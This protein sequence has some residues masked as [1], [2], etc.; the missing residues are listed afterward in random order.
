MEKRAASELMAAAQ[1]FDEELERFGKLAEAVNRGPLNSQKT[2]E[3]AA[4]VFDDIGHAEKRLS[5]VAQALVTALNAARQQQESHAAAIQR[6]A[7][8]FE[9]RT[10]TAADLLRR[11]GAMGQKAA[12][13]NELALDIAAKSA[14][15]DG[16]ASA[17]LLGALA[18]L[19]TR[20]AE[21]A[22]GASS[23]TAAARGEDF[24]DIA[25]QADS[26]RQQIVAADGKVA[27]IEKS[28]GERR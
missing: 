5:E 10:A 28:L 14:N 7:A 19:R 23:L 18:Q 17:D 15:G 1:A 12:D 27:A 24:E 4:H 26:L 13:L 2:L 25:R 8:L 20:M 3:R 11:Y 22:E 9:Q 6:R 21:V 16:G